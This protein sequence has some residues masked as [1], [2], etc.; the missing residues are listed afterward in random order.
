MFVV[1]GAE[2]L[3]VVQIIVYAGAILV[4]FL[5]VIMLLNLGQL[6]PGDPRPIQRWL[7]LYAALIIGLVVAFSIHAAGD[8]FGVRG[9]EDVEAVAADAVRGGNTGALAAKLYGEYIFPFEITSLLLTV[10]VVGAVVLARR[11]PD[12]ERAPG[13]GGGEGS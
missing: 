13:S 6:P 8:R 3:A 9:K 5:F 2:F 10:A 4:F 12:E 1:L 7:G 11:R